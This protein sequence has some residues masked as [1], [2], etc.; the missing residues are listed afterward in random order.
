MLANRLRLPTILG[1]LLAGALLGPNTPG[2]IADVEIA[3]QLAEIGVILLMFGVGLHF[4]VK[5]LVRVQRIALP[6]AIIQMSLT[7][8]FCLMVAM[9]LKHSFAESLVF[10]ITLSV[11]STV[12]LLRALEQHKL[13]D[14]AVLARQQLAG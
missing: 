4:S 6:G 2:F 5:D 8:T 9:L 1:Y 14:S 11:A 13:S 10:G 12:V 3:E 7:T